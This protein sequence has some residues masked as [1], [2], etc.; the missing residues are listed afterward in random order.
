MTDMHDVHIALVEAA[1]NARTER[2][3]NLAVARLDG[4]FRA[5]RAILGDPEHIGRLVVSA[6][7]HYLAQGIDRPMCGGL[8]LDWTPEVPR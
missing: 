4:F 1:N 7:T 6:D 2:D 3:H 8:W 5:A